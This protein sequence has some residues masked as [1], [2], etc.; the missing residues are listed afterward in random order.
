MCPLINRHCISVAIYLYFTLSLASIVLG[1]I[2]HDELYHQQRKK[3]MFPLFSWFF[4]ITFLSLY[5]LP[6]QCLL[7]GLSH[8]SLSWQIIHTI[9]HQGISV[10]EF[11]FFLALSY[12]VTYWLE[13]TLACTVCLSRKERTVPS[14]VSNRCFQIDFDN[15]AQAVGCQDVLLSQRWVQLAKFPLLILSLLAFFLYPLRSGW[16]T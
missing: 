15:D 12:T 1:A 5:L 8:H 16:L 3:G 14:F 4:F 11:D 9:H 10:D 6:S 7:F 2:T 13:I